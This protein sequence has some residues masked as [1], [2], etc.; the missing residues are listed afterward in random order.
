[1]TKDKIPIRKS[2][3]TLMLNT[4]Y[5]KLIIMIL[6]IIALIFKSSYVFSNGT[7]YIIFFV[8]GFIL[9][10]AMVVLC[11]Y[12]VFKQ[13]LIS[14]ILT[15]ILDIA[16]RLRIFKKKVEATDVDVISRRY[17]DEI[18]FIYSHKA[19]VVLGFIL[20]FI[21]RVLLFSVVYVIYRALG[22]NSLSYFEV[23]FIQVVVQVSIEAFPLPGVVGLSEAMLH[24]IFIMIFASSLAD[25]GMLLTRT[26]T[27]YIPLLVS[28]IVILLYNVFAN[29]PK[30]LTK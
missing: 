4:A 28:G 23:L 8:L 15:K 19:V 13:D 25:V 1:M 21:Q 30:K 10:L 29:K 18:S 16:R 11:L 2:Y 22:F 5:F 7:I 12:L 9:D 3:I 26:F 6:G 24:N 20:T 17:K 27:F 14:K